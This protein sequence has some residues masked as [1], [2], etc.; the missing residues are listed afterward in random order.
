MAGLCFSKTGA[1]AM[2]N[3]NGRKEWD[4]NFAAVPLERSEDLRNRGLLAT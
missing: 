2:V 4:G 1:C 3:T